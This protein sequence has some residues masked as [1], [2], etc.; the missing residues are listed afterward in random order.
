MKICPAALLIMCAF[1]A[2]ACS[3]V[4]QAAAA[5]NAPDSPATS[6]DADPVVTL[7]GIPAPFQGRWRSEGRACEGSPPDVNVMYVESRKLIFWGSFAQVLEITSLG[8][9]DLLLA[10][11]YPQAEGSAGESQE[12]GSTAQPVEMIL[13]LSGDQ[14]MLTTILSGRNMEV[15]YRCPPA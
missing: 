3:P 7:N 13:R 10:L 14:D 8:N 15:R 6:L 9:S 12:D 5:R 11:E 4:D 2:V 1:A